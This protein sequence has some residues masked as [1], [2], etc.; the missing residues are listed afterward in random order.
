[1]LSPKP[2]QSTQKCREKVETG[3]LQAAIMSYADLLFSGGTTDA[4][5][6][7][8]LGLNF[9]QG[10]ENQAEEF[11]VMP[12]MP[13]PL[14]LQ[15]QNVSEP[16]EKRRKPTHPAPAAATAFDGVGASFHCNYCGKDI[17]QA[18]RIK[19]AK[20]LDFDLCINCFSVG[21]ELHP[22]QNNH[23]YRVVEVLK[24]PV[25]SESWSADEVC[26]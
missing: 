19:C 7:P 11:G 14:S 3:L 4:E 24:F 8:D 17:S 13:P 21:A 20:C 23:P 9:D 12:D 5:A 26:P 25:Y 2:L 6:Q 22:H 10:I 15:I 16:R 1:M 18:V